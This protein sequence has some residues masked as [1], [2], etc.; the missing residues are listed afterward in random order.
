MTKYKHHENT[1]TKEVDNEIFVFNR[2]CGKMY[3]FS[4]VGKIIWKKL[5]ARS[6]TDDIL[7]VVCAEYNI[8]TQQAREDV[9]TFLDSLSSRHLIRSYE[10]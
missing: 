8:D 4:E 3:S 7:Q 5:E 6:S 9:S 2:E 10:Q 1:S